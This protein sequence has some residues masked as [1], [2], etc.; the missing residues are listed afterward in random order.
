MIEI[1]DQLLSKNRPFCKLTALKAIIIHWTANTNKGANAQ[2]NARYFNSDQYLTKKNGEKV[3]I[4]ASAHYVVDDKQIIRCIPDDE[5]GYHVGSKAGYKELIY[6]EIGVPHSGRLNDYTIGIEMCVNSDSDFSVTRQNTIEL[7]RYLLK[8]HNLTTAN[9]YRHFDITGKDCPKM[10]LDEVI[11][12]QFK[13]EINDTTD[14]SYENVKLRVNTATL[15]VRTGS[16]TNY[17]IKRKLN[18][19][20]IVTK[21]GQDGLWY[22][23]GDNEWVHSSY[24]VV[25]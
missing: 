3:K 23:I 13:K 15:N 18:S 11:W 21:M 25:L 1:N 8:A 7:I 20:D 14:E 19:G 16:G 17:P 12:Q 24:L 4:S 10:M 6:T 2:A 22:K 5:V 9:V